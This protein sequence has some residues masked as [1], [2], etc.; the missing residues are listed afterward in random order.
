MVLRVFRPLE[1]GLVGL[2]VGLN[3]QIIL[4]RLKL[5]SS[6]SEDL[7]AVGCCW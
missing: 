7:E 1:E 2:G 3:E 4:G 5:D 6:K